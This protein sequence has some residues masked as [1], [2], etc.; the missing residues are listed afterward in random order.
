MLTAWPLAALLGRPTIPEMLDPIAK[1]T[2]QKLSPRETQVLELVSSG[3]TNMQVAALLGVGVHAVKFHLA[4]IYRKLGVGNRT[5]AT[6]V[7]L[8]GAAG[9]LREASEAEGS[10]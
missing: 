4:C 2:G 6:S 7:Y 10:N 9:V 5:E 1:P 3:R 8:R